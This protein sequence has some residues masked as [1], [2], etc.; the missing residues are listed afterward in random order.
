MREK[1]DKVLFGAL[2]FGIEMM[3]KM[4]TTT[5]GF[6]LG[7]FAGSL[8][9]KVADKIWG[10]KLGQKFK[11]LISKKKDANVMNVY[12]VGG[13]VDGNAGL[14]DNLTSGKDNDAGDVVEDVIED[15]TDSNNGKKSLLRRGLDFA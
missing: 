3:S 13:S 15:V 10:T 12:I 9:G 1:M 11:S 2:G 4:L 7:G 6:M 5:A 14:L 8:I